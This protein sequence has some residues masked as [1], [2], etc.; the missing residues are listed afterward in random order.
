MSG[1]VTNSDLMTQ[2]NDHGRRLADLEQGMSALTSEVESIKQDRTWLR[3]TL[4][5]V[6]GAVDEIR[7]N[8]TMISQRSELAEQ[9]VRGLR[10]DIK[11]LS[12]MLTD[13]PC[14]VGSDCPTPTPEHGGQNA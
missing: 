4:L 8:V 14:V 9:D 2:L 5:R 12:K 3:A 10:H 6:L 1:G 11:H 13:R 7:H